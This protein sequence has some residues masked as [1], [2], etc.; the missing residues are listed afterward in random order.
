VPE[1]PGLPDAILALQE[2]ARQL[3]AIGSRLDRLEMLSHGGKSVYVGDG[4]IMTRISLRHWNMAFLLEAKDL[5]LAPPLIMNGYHEIDLTDFFVNTIREADHCLDVGA[6]FGYFT[7]I[8]GRW[9]PRGKTVAL[10]PDPKIYELLR[11]N[12]YINSLE[13]HVSARNAAA[14]DVEGMLTLHRRVTRSG[15]TSLARIPDA[16]LATIGEPPSVPFDIACM[17]IDSLLPEFTGRLDC[18][19]IDVE[20]AEPLVIRGAGRT[21]GENP[22]LRIVMEWAP[23][24]IRGAGF[25]TGDFLRELDELGLRPAVITT[26]G[27]T[28]ELS[29]DEV[30]AQPYFPGILLTRSEPAGT[31]P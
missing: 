1:G 14:G 17:P 30:N 9:A 5:L 23:S 19:K 13:G 24:Q 29:W 18:L 8:M 21:I 3:E 26:G 2:L 7:C 28:E 16:A 22:A 31:S 25:D 11:D 6:N 20:G 27:K 15:N 4:R 10:E 12:I